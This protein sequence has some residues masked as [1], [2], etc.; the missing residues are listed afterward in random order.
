[1][2]YPDSFIASTFVLVHCLIY[3]DKV[4][5]AYTRLL[6]YNNVFIVECT[7]CENSSGAAECVTCQAKQ[8]AFWRQQHEANPHLSASQLVDRSPQVPF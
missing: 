4:E 8:E 5:R 6:T 7:G 3:P 2:K 1:M